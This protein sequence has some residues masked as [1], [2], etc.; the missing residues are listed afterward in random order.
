LKVPYDG[1]LSFI[2]FDFNLRR[3]TKQADDE[4]ELDLDDDMEDADDDEEQEE[5]EEEDDDEDEDGG[6][7]KVKGMFPRFNA[8]S[9]RTQPLRHWLMTHFDHPYPEVRPRGYCPPR[10]PYPCPFPSPSSPSSPSLSQ[11]LITQ[12]NLYPHP[13]LSLTFATYTA[14]CNALCTLVS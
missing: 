5:E 11:M 13:V 10:H 8:Q 3:Y 12:L 9:K 6:E 7:V 4:E 2:A 14:Q 1:P